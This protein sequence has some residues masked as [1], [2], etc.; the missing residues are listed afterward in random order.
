LN[1]ASINNTFTII[2]YTEFKKLVISGKEVWIRTDEITSMQF[3]VKG[4]VLYSQHVVPRPAELASLGNLLEKKILQLKPII[5]ESKM[6]PIS[7]SFKSFP[8]DSDEF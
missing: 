3:N 1:S 2:L 4:L 8:D 6:R 7:L 5:I